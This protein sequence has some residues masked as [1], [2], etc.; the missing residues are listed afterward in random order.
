VWALGNLS[1]TDP[2]S[3]PAGPATGFTNISQQTASFL[4]HNGFA[5][6]TMF[7]KAATDTFSAGDFVYLIGRNEDSGTRIDGMAEPQP[8][9]GFAINPKQWLPTF[10][11]TN[12]TQ[13]IPQPVLAG[14]KNIGGT[15]SSTTSVATWTGTT[16]TVT[17]TKPNSSIL[18]GA[19]VTGT[20]IA[21]N[22]TVSDINGSTLTL[23]QNTTTSE[24]GVTL[25]IAFAGCLIQNIATW[26]SNDT[27]NTE[28]T[29]TWNLAGH[30]GYP[31]GG[32]VESVLSTPVDENTT[33]N[34]DGA[35]APGENTGN[36]FF[37]GYLGVS[38]AEGTNGAA[39]SGLGGILTYNGVAE[40][41]QTIDN[42]SY[43]FWSYEHMYYLTS[44]TG[45]LSG[46]KSDGPLASQLG[47]VTNLANGV[48]GTYAPYDSSGV[49]GD[50]LGSDNKDGA[51]VLLEAAST[52]A[53]TSGNVFRT[54]EGGPYNLNY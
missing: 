36:A 52:A 18:I 32:D 15:S 33:F 13:D 2:I 8:L 17:L 14:T 5:P 29:V 21:S 27:L 7:S 37:I 39:K 22:T 34:N 49:I 44:G 24:S 51:G 12:N 42:G 25:T 47:F 28:T 23:S 6:F 20:G 30:S 48:A 45:A 46:S 53:T 40:S 16:T 43:S 4:T 9:T 26:P 54:V 50:G 1:N 38:D 41:T 19:A 3:G 35:V 10:S 31:A 11:G